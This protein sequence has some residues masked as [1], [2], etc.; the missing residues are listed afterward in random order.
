MMPR[1][2]GIVLGGTSERNVWTTDV[3]EAEK[4]RII[5]NHVALFKSMR[6]PGAPAA[7]SVPTAGR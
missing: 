6:T 4:A 5:E 1:T 3:N 7:P 2:D